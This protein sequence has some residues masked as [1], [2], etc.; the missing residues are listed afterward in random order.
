MK[1]NKPPRMAAWLLGWLLK[2]EGNTALGDFEEYYND[3]AAEHGERRARWWY[4]GQVLRLVPDQLSERALWQLIMFRSYIVL[5]FRALRKDKVSSVINVAGLSA[6]IGIA[7]VMFVFIQEINTFDDFHEQGDRTYLIGHTVEEDGESYAFG[8]SPTPLGPLLATEISH[9]ERAVRYAEQDVVVQAGD[10]QFR[11]TLSFADAGFF[12]M[13]SFPLD[14]GDGS[15][16]VDPSGVVISQKVA[17]KYFRGTD[18][19]GKEVAFTYGN[20]QKETLVVRGVSADFPVKSSLKFD[21]LVSFEKLPATGGPD[22]GD[23]ASFAD[24]TFIQLRSPDDAQAVEAQLANYVLAQNDASASWQVRSYFL[25][26]IRNPNPFTAWAVHDRLLSAPP[27]WES[28]GVGVVG[29]LVLLVVCFNYITI[30]LGSVHRRLRE[31]GIRKA[32]GAEK[33]QLIT[34]F[35]TENLVLCLVALL[36]GLVIAQMVVLP[37]FYD[38][39][40]MALHVDLFGNPGVWAFLLGA[41]VFIG[42]VSGAYPAFY[43]SSFQPV[44]ILRGKLKLAE[45][46]GLMGVLTTVQFVLTIMTISVALFLVSLDDALTDTD[47]GYD[48]EGLVMVPV[49]TTDDFVRMRQDF[50]GLPHVVGVAGAAHHIGST[51]KMVSVDTEGTEAQVMFFGVGPEYLST[52]GLQ[53]AAG[54]MFRDDAVADSSTSIVINRTFATDRGWDNPVGMD[55]RIGEHLFQVAGMVEDFMI[56]P[57]KGSAFPVVFGLVPDNAFRYIAV[58]TPNTA[59]QPAESVEAFR[60]VDVFREY[61]LILRLTVQVTRFLGIFALLISCMGLFGMASQRAARR[62]REVGI[63]KTMGAS[64]LNVVFLVNRSFLFM[65]LTATCIATPVCWLMLSAALSL[66]PMDI[67]MSIQ[68]FILT[69]VLVAVLAAVSL[70]HQTRRLVRTNPADVLRCE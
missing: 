8:T 33:R 39:T 6:A 22:P 70:S 51:Q 69:N 48:E 11:E 50:S 44:E 67:P 53:V 61:D 28:I 30:S 47:W 57:L 9:I 42:L 63:R 3:L 68:P 25:D 4:R 17:R 13:L 21:F 54:R 5:G 23:W 10:D 52:M 1:F 40:N 66:S 55:V 56:Y 59:F 34:Q 64:P 41:L 27:V 18:A 2:D 60:Q 45:K 58:R 46:K 12:D 62:M 65:L 49:S 29:L 31:I 37:L 16:L 14:R 43:I 36:G 38:S 26:N 15:A 19:I 32:S 35:L 20:G 7:L 24:G